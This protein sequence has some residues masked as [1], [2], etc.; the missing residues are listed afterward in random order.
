MTIASGTCLGPYQVAIP[1]GAGGMG[2]VYRA[3][4]TR[5]DRNIAIKVLPERLAD[6]PEALARFENEAK[7]VAALSHPNILAIH[8]V[9]REQGI[10][11][12][13]L[14][15]LEGET[16]RD[17]VRREPI[18]WQ[19]ALEIGAAI[20]DGL[21]AAHARGIIHRDL[22]PANI[23]VTTDGLVK[24]LDFG[25]ARIA[26]PLYKECQSDS[27]I[28]P[29]DAPTAAH[30][31]GT[32]LLVGT[33]GYVSPERL[34]GL[35]GE[36]QSDIFSF[37]CVMYEMLTGQRAFERNTVIET[38]A[39]ILNDDTPKPA[40]TG[41]EVP[42]E[43][44]QLI[45]RCLEKNPKRRFKSASDLAKM[46]RAPN[47]MSKADSDGLVIGTVTQN[48]IESLVVLPLN[49]LSD[50]SE[51]DYFVDGMTD[52]LI[53]NLA[54]I[55]ALRVISRTSAMQYKGVK[56]PLPEIARQLNVQAVVEGSV[57]RVGDRV[58]ITALLIEAAT[59]QLIWGETYD[60]E[61]RDILTLQSEVA[62]TIASE[63]DIQLTPDEQTRLTCVQ[64][65]DPMAH[66]FYLKGRYHWNKRGHR[67][68]LKA[69]ECFKQS[70]EMDAAFAVTYAGLADC[71]NILGFY[72]LLPPAEAF[73]KAMAAAEKAMM[74]DD[75]I[76][77]AHASLAFVKFYYEWEWSE[78]EREFQR[79]LKLNPG[80][81]TA[82]HWYAE[83]LAAV[84]Q[85]EACIAEFQR[86][87]ELDPL[88]LIIGGGIGWA[89]YFARQYDNSIHHCL[90][91]LEMD[92][93]FIPARLFLG[94]AWVQSEKYDEAIAEFRNVLNL[95]GGATEIMA[96]LGHALAMAGRID[97][98]RKLLAELKRLLKTKH[99]PAYGIAIVN[100]GLQDTEQA[101]LWLNKAIEERSHYMPLLLVDPRLDRLRSDPRFD[102]LVHRVGL[103][104]VKSKSSAEPK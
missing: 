16:L 21:A 40:D 94:Q 18:P 11:F 13:V 99:V 24:I 15:L 59:D 82:H 77:E 42:Y 69:I 70:I 8:D 76:A 48:P 19:N 100:I 51:Q 104:R 23:F 92:A 4:D 31:I 27:R 54:K 22:K 26:E 65:V 83:F 53:A 67:D 38:A 41:V 37:G 63:I 74:I 89:N 93:N 35:P 46:L 56:K 91:T 33:I 20:A 45:N 96:E 68:L 86:A 80:Y 88:S 64:Q 50:Q 81:A 28:A 78:A 66:E 58:R 85:P 17:Q 84:E 43:V 55:K 36:A 2:E 5:L 49:N 14:E 47:K 6:D 25:L 30:E 1:L 60:R 73:P 98:S 62:R 29:H 71:Y 44:E 3:T 102:Q 52:A 57:M 90:K 103:P 34:R 32:G 95:S 12:V 75:R 79:A 39:A 10:S 101:F 7:A 61:L 9:G 87:H 72:S 97:E